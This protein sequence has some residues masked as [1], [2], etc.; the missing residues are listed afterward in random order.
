QSNLYTDNGNTYTRTSNRK[1]GLWNQRQINVNRIDPD[2][3]L[4]GRPSW[5]TSVPQHLPIADPNSFVK[6]NFTDPFGDLGA[7]FQRPFFSSPPRFSQAH[8]SS[9]FVTSRHSRHC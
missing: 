2:P 3:D 6:T 7:V 9:D 4:N 1:V 5:Q 8:P